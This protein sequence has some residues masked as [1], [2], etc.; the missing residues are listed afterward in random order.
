MACEEE[1][2]CT[3]GGAVDQLAESIVQCPICDEPEPTP[4][5]MAIVQRGPICDACAGK[6]R[7]LIRRD[8]ER[9]DELEGAARFE[10]G[11]AKAMERERE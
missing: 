1:F 11:M 8:E 5:M 6:L 9:R 4:G 3:V 2:V 10:E 7:D